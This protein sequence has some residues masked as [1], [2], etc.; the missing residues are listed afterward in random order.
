MTLLLVKII[1]RSMIVGQAK[2]SEYCAARVGFGKRRQHLDMHDMVYTQAGRKYSL[3][4][5]VF[6]NKV[7]W[8]PSFV[9]G[10]A[11]TSSR[12]PCCRAGICS[13]HVHSMTYK[14][15][16]HGPFSETKPVVTSS[17]SVIGGII[18]WSAWIVVLDPRHVDPR[19]GNKSVVVGG[20]VSYGV[21][22]KLGAI[23]CCRRRAFGKVDT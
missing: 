18:S 10:S 19:L 20:E 23:A 7:H 22:G 4:I 2:H 15:D 6:P 3:S 11:C 9:A 12:S 21:H 8:G 1:T 5:G 13:F 17:T 14:Y 16:S